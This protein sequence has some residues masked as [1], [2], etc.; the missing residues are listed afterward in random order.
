VTNPSSPLPSGTS[1]EVTAIDLIT[2]L[3]REQFETDAGYT[4][5]EK[6]WRKGWNARAN[7][8]IARL[9]GERPL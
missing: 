3:R 5:A 4:D 1:A 9:A 8:L 2:L 6:A 7:D